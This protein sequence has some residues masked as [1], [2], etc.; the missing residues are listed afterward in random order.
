MGSMVAIA[1]RERD[2]VLEEGR[3]RGTSAAQACIAPPVTGENNV[4]VVVVE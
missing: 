3:A 1:E 4:V 2:G